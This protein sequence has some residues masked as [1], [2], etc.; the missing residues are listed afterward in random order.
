MGIADQ[1]VAAAHHSAPL[2]P[3]G[4]GRSSRRRRPSG[5][6]PPLPHPLQTT[7]I[8]WMTASVVLVA[9]SFAVFS[10]VLRGPAVT[11]TA[12][13]DAVV[14]WLAGL[15]PPGLSATMKALAAPGSW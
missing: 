11:V 2:G 12:V 10:G 7:G 3:A 14:R 5:R 15:D 1:P 6:P 8:S 13:D 4:I 9:L